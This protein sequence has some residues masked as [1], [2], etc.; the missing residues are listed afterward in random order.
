MKDA[1]G[2]LS[3][4]IVA[5]SY[6]DSVYTTMNPHYFTPDEFGLL[7]NTNFISKP[8]APIYRADLSNTSTGVFII[9]GEIPVSG[10]VTGMEFWYSVT[11]S[12]FN[13]NNYTLY[14][15]Q[16]YANGSL[17]PHKDSFG[18]AFIEQIQL[19]GFTTNTYWWVTRAQGPNGTSEFSQPS[20]PIGWSSTS[21][22]VVGQQ[23][24]DN[25]ISGSKVTPPA[26]NTQPS[27]SGGFFDTLGPIAG[28]SL[29]AAAIYYG[30]NKGIFN[31][32]LPKDW[33]PSGG[34]N[35]PSNGSDTV[36]PKTTIYYTKNDG[37]PTD[38]PQ[39][40]DQQTIV[41]DATP[42][43]APIEDNANFDGYTTPPVN[44]ADNGGGDYVG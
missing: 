37:T 2:F 25:S 16:N 33:I 28:V 34:G 26:S 15:T 19:Q 38:N 20:A 8:N 21:T 4:Q 43:T 11:T 7:T 10:N 32:I 36:Q 13:S 18:N 35:D 14:T 27:Q 24:L 40:G 3:V 23:V 1:T 12:T 39:P 17:Y 30:Y 41:A 42:N 5:M 22:V 6:N 31:D 44:Y 29:G 9:Q